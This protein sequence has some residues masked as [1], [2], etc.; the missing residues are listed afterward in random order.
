MV[1]VQVNFKTDVDKDL[2]AGLRIRYK[3]TL[4][5]NTVARKVPAVKEAWAKAYAESLA[6]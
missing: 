6:L 2:V 1:V 5:D 3:S 4:I